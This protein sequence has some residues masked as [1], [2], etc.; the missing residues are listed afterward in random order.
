MFYK[1]F[2]QG[3]ATHYRMLQLSM[4]TKNLF[5][6]EYNVGNQRRAWDCILT[7]QHGMSAESEDDVYIDPLLPLYE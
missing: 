7:S 1:H 3:Q 6:L 4:H 5:C 2:N